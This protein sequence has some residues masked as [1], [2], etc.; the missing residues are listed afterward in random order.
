MHA[1]R[2]VSRQMTLSSDRSILAITL[3]VALSTFSLNASAGSQAPANRNDSVESI[4][5]RG[6]PLGDVLVFNAASGGYDTDDA[7]KWGRN[8]WTCRSATD[9]AAGACPTSPVW[10]GGGGPTP[11]RLSF[12]EETTGASAVL[13]LIGENGYSRHADCDGKDVPETVAATRVAIHQAQLAEIGTCS[14]GRHWD[15]RSLFVK[16][17]ATE[18]AKL[19]SGGIWKANLQL[20]LRLWGGSN[21]VIATFQAAI[22][23]KVTDRN[24]IQIYLPGAGTSTPTIDLQLMKLPNGAMMSGTSTIDMCLYDGYNSQSAWFDVSASDNL[25]IDRRDSGSYSVLLDSDRSGAYASRID[26]NASLKYGGKRTELPNNQVVRLQSV[27]N[28][29]GRT[30]TLPGIPV[31]VVCTPT[32][33]TLETPKVQSA[34]K[35]PGRYSS[36]LTVTFSPSSSSL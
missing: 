2:T 7:A 1:C 22:K 13:G 11:I 21:P 33:L 36:T 23:L 34:F 10:N 25:T 9:T 20:D 16:I 15:G 31:P 32:P 3:A 17:P 6:E 18:I 12:T 14:T 5:D 4:R 24:N 8:T 26:Y 28:S 19:P 35:R 30:V 29:A 27:N